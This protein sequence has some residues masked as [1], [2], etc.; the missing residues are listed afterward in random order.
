MVRPIARQESRSPLGVQGQ[1]RVFEGTLQ[2]T[3]KDAGGQKLADTSAQ[4]SVGAPEWGDY[5]ALLPFAVTSRQE[6]TLE[7]YSL[8]ARDGS[9]QFLVT[10]P[11]VLLP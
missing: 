10:V 3:L 7:V 1:A 6:A 11:V 8:S 4:A 2:L 5:T 9:A